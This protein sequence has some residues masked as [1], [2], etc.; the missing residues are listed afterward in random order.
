MNGS[1]GT[2]TKS[3]IMLRPK[4]VDH[5]TT[6]HRCICQLSTA[7]TITVK[8]NEHCYEQRQNGLLLTVCEVK[9]DPRS[10]LCCQFVMLLSRWSLL[11]T[12]FRLRPVDTPVT[13]EP[14]HFANIANGPSERIGNNYDKQTRKEGK[15]TKVKARNG[16]TRIVLH[17]EA[18]LV[19]RDPHRI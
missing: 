3:P 19:T 7:N 2:S 10:F 1:V 17:A 14:C 9:I 12:S 16:R 13:S 5:S 6:R 11:K 4:Q 15:Q 8:D 18:R